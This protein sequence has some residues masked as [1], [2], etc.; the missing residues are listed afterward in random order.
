M[1]KLFYWICHCKLTS[2]ANTT[3][4]EHMNFGMGNCLEFHC[5]TGMQ[6]GPSKQMW[7]GYISDWVFPGCPQST[8]I[9]D[10]MTTSSW[11][12]GEREYLNF[13]NSS[14]FL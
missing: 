1:K 13:K 6:V 5:A 8:W 3:F 7:T 10:L 14:I 9:K 4:Y 12:V 2:R 11:M